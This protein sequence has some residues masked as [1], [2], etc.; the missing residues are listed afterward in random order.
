[1]L[2]Y[3]PNSTY[4]RQMHGHSR[5]NFIFVYIHQN[6]KDRRGF[7]ECVP[8]F[9]IFFTTH[10]SSGTNWPC[11]PFIMQPPLEDLHCLIISLGLHEIIMVNGSKRQW[12]LHTSHGH[13]LGMRR[14][15][16]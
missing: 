7:N 14:Q 5:V 16:H 15:R 4:I 12:R 2:H 11:L 6:K 8:S 9:Q 1:M 13:D 10:N 3:E